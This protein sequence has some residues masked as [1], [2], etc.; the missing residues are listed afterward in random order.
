MRA[1]SLASPRLLSDSEASA[2]RAALARAELAKAAASLAKAKASRDAIALSLRSTPQQRS[3]ADASLRA[4]EKAYAGLLESK[5]TTETDEADQVIELPVALWD[6]HSKGLLIAPPNEAP[7][8]A[9]ARGYG[10]DALVYGSIIEVSDYILVKIVFHE[11]ASGEERSFEDACSYDTVESMVDR[12]AAGLSQAILGRDSGSLRITA[13]PANSAIYVEGKLRGVGK[14]ELAGLSPGMLSIRAEAPGY[15]GAMSIAT[16]EVGAKASLE[17]TLERGPSRTILVESEPPGALV[18][19]DGAMLG[20]TPLETEVLDIPHIAR[21]SLKGYHDRIFS[22]NPDIDP[23]LHEGKSRITIKLAPDGLMADT[24]VLS[25]KDEFYRALGWVLVGMGVTS[26]TWGLFDTMQKTIS[27]TGA[28]DA[29]LWANRSVSLGF[30]AASGAATVLASYWAATSLAAY[31]DAAN[32][33]YG[34]GAATAS[35]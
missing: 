5:A 10:L 7:V 30:F 18:F 35:R 32:D 16:I 19:L 31:I 34:I 13:T 3:D 21:I 17:L 20:Q 24:A 14:V 11:R 33:P 26:L 27:A 22:I 1:T 8:A 9:L 28:S 4:A 23:D 12:I 15:R 2:R 25:R 29:E 6:G